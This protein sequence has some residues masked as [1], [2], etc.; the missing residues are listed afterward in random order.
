MKLR[1]RLSSMLPRYDVT[2]FSGTVK[3]GDLTIVGKCYK[4]HG[5]VARLVQS[6][7]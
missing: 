6:A 4:C 5:N 7:N 1:Y 2:N 3:A